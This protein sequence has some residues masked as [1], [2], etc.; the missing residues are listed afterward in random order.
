MEFGPEDKIFESRFKIKY[1]ILDCV[2]PGRA[3]DLRL[4]SSVAAY[5]DGIFGKEWRASARP[6]IH[7]VT[8]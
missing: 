6:D 5:L 4:N 7:G 3:E 2:I 1:I 8:E